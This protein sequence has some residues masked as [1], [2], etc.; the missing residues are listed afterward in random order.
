MTTHTTSPQLQPTPPIST[1]AN[2]L[3]I[4]SLVLGILSL[5]GFFIFAGIPAIITGIMSLKKK[6]KERGMS[7]AGIIMGGIS[8]LLSLLFIIFFVA[9]IILGVMSEP[10]TMEHIDMPSVEMDMPIESSRT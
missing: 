5:T 9:L 4:A 7:I 6:Q 2:G 8:T 10:S 1:D 3:A